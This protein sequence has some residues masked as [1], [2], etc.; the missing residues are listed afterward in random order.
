MFPSKRFKNM[1]I[2]LSS[3]PSTKNAKFMLVFPNYAK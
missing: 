2:V 3:A 1:L